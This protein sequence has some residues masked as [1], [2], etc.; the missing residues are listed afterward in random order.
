MKRFF[1]LGTSPTD[2]KMSSECRHSLWNACVQ[3]DFLILKSQLFLHAATC[4]ELLLLNEWFHLKQKWP[5]L[6]AVQWLR[7]MVF[8]CSTCVF[9]TWRSTCW[10]C[11]ALPT[12]HCGPLIVLPFPFKTRGCDARMCAVVRS[13]VSSNLQSRGVR[14]GSMTMGFL[15]K[16]FLPF[17][18]PFSGGNWLFNTC[19][20]AAE[21][22]DRTKMV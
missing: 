7:D 2:L 15:A 4:C 1:L 20:W 18:P 6:A 13:L 10:S 8:I 12:S 5:F 19:L 16:F 21:R 22:L 11:P 17:F 9:L 3:F 14:D